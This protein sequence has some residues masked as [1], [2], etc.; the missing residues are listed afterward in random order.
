MS[1]NGRK[2]D[3]PFTIE[4]Y[5]QRIEGVRKQMQQRCIE[6]LMVREPVNLYYLTGYN[7]IGFSNYTILFLPLEGEPCMLV[8]SM[9]KTVAVASSWVNDIA[10]WED[11]EN[12]YA[13]TRSLLDGHKW[14]NKKLAFE[15]STSYVSLDGYKALAA[16]VDREMTD[17]GHLVEAVR[18]V[19]SSTEIS[20]M[21]KAAEFSYA[22]MEAGMKAFAVGV[23]E[24]QVASKMY[25]AIVATGGENT[26]GEP[27][28]TCGTKSGIPHTTFH[29]YILQEGDAALLELAGVYNRYVAPI[30]RCAVLGPKFNPEIK[31]MADVCLEALNT[32]IDAIKPGT[33]SGEVDEACRGVI[34]RAGYYENFRKRTGYSVGCSYP[35][36][37]F[38]QMIDLKMNDP[39]VLLPGM[40]FHLPVALRKYGEFGVGLS[41]TVLVTETGSEVLTCF[42][43]K[44]FV[45]E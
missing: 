36:T 43:R 20:Y 31:I 15:N 44:L 34:E 40:V 45:I 24:N 2:P 14:I 4:E 12:P 28:V 23:T 5:R 41:E 30:M 26:S 3:T 33:T 18:E 42:P 32:A 37:L 1:N 13:L 6:V 19:K 29:R 22:S 27:I 39:R 38:E 11:H 9:E 10:V 17:G 35:P 16:A 21:R 8:R 7:T 25:A